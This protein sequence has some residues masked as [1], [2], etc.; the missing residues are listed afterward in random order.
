MGIF[1][2]FSFAAYFRKLQTMYINE[3]M[4]RKMEKKKKKDL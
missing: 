4:K 1:F 3:K 2:F